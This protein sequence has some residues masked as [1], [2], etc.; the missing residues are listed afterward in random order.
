VSSTGNVGIGT[1]TPETGLHLAK[2]AK[3]N[4]KSH[5]MLLIGEGKQSVNIVMDAQSI[6]AR[7]NGSPSTLRLNP[8]GGD[9]TLFEDAGKAGGKITFGADGNVGI[10]PAKAFAKL[11]VSEGPGKFATI[12]IGESNAGVGVI[13]YKESKLTMGFS[14]STAG[15]NNKEEAITVMKGG[16]VGIGNGQPKAKLH[17]QGDV[18][19][20]GKLSVGGKQVVSMMED[21][22]TEN[23]RLSSELSATK[24]MMASMNTNMERMMSE[25]SEMKATMAQ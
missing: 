3:A 2:G 8:D 23:K 20:T 1:E 21:M 4:L 25:M 10:G 14:R 13:R 22:M 18:L 6:V 17:V 5:G 12:A 11:H 19:I 16:N 7:K 9:V 24:E 15:G